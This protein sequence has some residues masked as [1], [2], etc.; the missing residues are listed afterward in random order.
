MR[1]R[2]QQDNSSYLSD[3]AFLLIIF[4]ILLAGSTTIRELTTDLN[5]GMQAAASEATPPPV[6]IHIQADGTWLT[7]EG[8]LASRELLQT[9]FQQEP[10][11]DR[12]LYLVIDPAAA[13]RQ[14]TPLLALCEEQGI[15]V[16]MEEGA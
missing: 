2:G 1:R 16:F 9:R 15:S 14:V 6:I 11:K 12:A 13:W 3:L 10:S 4:F 8:E 7:N 5:D